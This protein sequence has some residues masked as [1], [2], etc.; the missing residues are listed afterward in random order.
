MFFPA[1]YVYV[2]ISL[3]LAVF[4]GSD[5]CMDEWMNGQVQEADEP[6]LAARVLPFSTTAESP[7]RR[8]RPILI[9][10]D[11]GRTP[12]AWIDKGDL[13]SWPTQTVDQTY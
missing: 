12:P 10:H 9:R 5:S 3:S 4:V 1:K 13:P 6:M 11:D 7:Q 8:V 2:Y